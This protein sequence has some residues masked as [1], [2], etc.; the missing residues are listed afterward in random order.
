MTPNISWDVISLAKLLAFVILNAA[1]ER[2]GDVIENNYK[3]TSG[4]HC[5]MWTE[6]RIYWVDQM[7]R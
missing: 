5:L 3:G 7:S 1:K 2:L 4:S 6:Y